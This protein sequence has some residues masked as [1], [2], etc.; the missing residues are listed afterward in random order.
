M[1]SYRK[2][3]T[4]YCCPIL[5][6]KHKPLKEIHRQLLCIFPAC[7]VWGLEWQFSKPTSNFWNNLARWKESLHSLQMKIGIWQDSSSLYTVLY[8]QLLNFIYKA[9]QLL[10]LPCKLI[11]YYKLS[12][13]IFNF[14]QMVFVVVLVFVVGDTQIWK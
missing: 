4:K 6:W 14:F 12:L 1:Q 7:L 3:N 10:G 8:L 13:T 5:E 2:F 9:A 11:R